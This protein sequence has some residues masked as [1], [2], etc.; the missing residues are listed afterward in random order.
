MMTCQQV[1]TDAVK[2][3]EAAFLRAQEEL[4]FTRE[5]LETTEDELAECQEMLDE[6]QG[7]SLEQS[8]QHT[9]LQNQIKASPE[10]ERMFC[11]W[12]QD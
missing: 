5:R 3:L 4:N 1:K 8:Y 7:K 2:S 11:K 12:T 10:K 9:A 6:L